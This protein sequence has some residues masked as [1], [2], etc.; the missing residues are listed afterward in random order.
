MA[1]ERPVFVTSFAA[2]APAGVF[3][4]AGGVILVDDEG[5]PLGAM[6]ISGDI[7]DNDEICALVGI[8]ASRLTAQGH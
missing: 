2:V 1:A 4:A 5:V 8:A 7:S 6:G 3:P